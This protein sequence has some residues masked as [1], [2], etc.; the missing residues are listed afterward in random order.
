MSAA[1]GNIAFCTAFDRFAESV[2]ESIMPRLR[3]CEHDIL[4][5]SL[6]SIEVCLQHDLVY[7]SR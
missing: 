7:L 4:K 5:Y 6:M 2:N 1:G 3:H